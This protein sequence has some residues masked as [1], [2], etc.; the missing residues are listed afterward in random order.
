VRNAAQNGSHNIEHSASRTH[1]SLRDYVVTGIPCGECCST[2]CAKGNSRAMQV[3]VCGSSESWGSLSYQNSGPYVA[4][5]QARRRIDERFE[6]DT[7]ET[8]TA[9]IRLRWGKSARSVVTPAPDII[10]LHRIRRG[11]WSFGVACR[12]W[13]RTPVPWIGEATYLDL[14]SI[15]YGN[16]CK[17]GR[18]HYLST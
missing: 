5:V 7:T 3:A 18:L 11:K 1:T 9:R 16:C 15:A 4:I 17:R 14:G 13:T 10:I 2:P 6:Y 8:A 12:C